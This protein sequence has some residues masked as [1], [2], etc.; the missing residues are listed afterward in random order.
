MNSKPLLSLVSSTRAARTARTIAAR[1][2]AAALVF[3]MSAAL[4][5]SAPVQAASITSLV[6]SVKFDDD[7]GVA[8]DL[9]T[10]LDPN[11]VDEQGNPL[12]VL[13]AREKSD[14]VAALLLDNPKTKIDAE[15]RAGEN[16]LMLAALNGDLDLVKLL[17]TKGA[18]VNKTG[19]A[20]LHYAAANGNDD[21]AKLL[22]GYSAQVDALSPNG[23]TPLMM[24]ARGDHMSTVKL[25]LD[26]GANLNAKNQIG[27]NALD[28][29]K[30]Y[31][32]PDAIKGLSARM[33]QPDGQSGNAAAPQ[34][35]AK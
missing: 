31:K 30:Q 14:K 33:A 18:Q 34:N 3:G 12:I 23:T 10:G 13:A 6:K 17:I 9:G 8:S 19:W 16:A 5:A 15:D 28:F 24:A 22:L 11:A 20:P 4:L 26:S 25:L 32:A 7:K 2:V 21:I 27:M 1:R 35:G 29:A